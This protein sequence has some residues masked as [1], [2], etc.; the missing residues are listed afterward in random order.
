MGIGVV[1]TKKTTICKNKDF[2]V[3]R[4]ETMAALCCGKMP[5]NTICIKKKGSWQQFNLEEEKFN[6]LREL[7]LENVEA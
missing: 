7:L 1:M 6:S 3:I 4:I 5:F 2:E